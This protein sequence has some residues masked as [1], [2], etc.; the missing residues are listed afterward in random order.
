VTTHDNAD[1]YYYNNVLISD[2]VLPAWFTGDPGPYDYRHH[3]T[4]PFQVLPDGYC[5]IYQDG[6]WTS[7]QMRGGELVTTQDDDDVE[8]P[9]IRNRNKRR[10]HVRELISVRDWG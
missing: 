6:S 10:E 9:C 8:R 4:A 2:F 3:C 5:S 7:Y 1:S